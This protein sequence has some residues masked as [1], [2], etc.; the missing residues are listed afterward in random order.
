MDV[1]DVSHVRRWVQLL[2]TQKATLQANSRRKGELPK[3]RKPLEQL[4]R[5]FMVQLLGQ[6]MMAPDMNHLIHHSFVAPPYQPSTAAFGS[7]QQLYIQ[8]LRLETHH[9]GFY[10]ILRSVTPAMVLTGIMAI[11]E[12]EKG[13]G[14]SLQLYQ[15]KTNRYQIADD[16]LQEGRLCIIKEPYYKIMNDRSYGLRVDHV[17]DLIWLS[18][19]DDR[20]PTA[21]LP[22]I[23]ELDVD[24]MLLKEDGNRAF[25]AGKPYEAAKM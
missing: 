13:D 3:D 19:D 10:I 1:D 7:L 22:R 17:S 21:W 5:E 14:V 24:A 23:Q 16:I 20:I 15:Q 9:R 2:G 12:D 18:M 25:K 11:M 8:N 6:K 4:V